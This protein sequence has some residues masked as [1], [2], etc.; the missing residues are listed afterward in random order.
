M[1][2]WYKKQ[3][4]ETRL[5]ERDAAWSCPEKHQHHVG[6]HILAER[7]GDLARKLLLV[8]HDLAR[9]DAEASRQCCGEAIS[10][11][12]F[13]Q[14]WKSRREKTPNS[15][16]LRDQG[17]NGVICNDRKRWKFH[18]WHV[19]FRLILAK[20]REGA[21]NGRYDWGRWALGVW[22]DTSLPPPNLIPT[23]HYSPYWMLSRIG[24]PTLPRKTAKSEMLILGLFKGPCHWSIN[25]K[26]WVAFKYISEHF[27]S[28]LFNISEI[29]RSKCW[30]KWLYS[31]K[32]STKRK[33]SSPAHNSLK[34]FK[35][36]VTIT[37]SQGQ[38]SL[39][40]TTGGGKATHRLCCACTE[41]PPSPFL[42]T[43]VQ[44]QPHHAF[45]TALEGLQRETAH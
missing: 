38:L 43:L 42:L 13:S 15:G 37:S 34:R 5:S 16:A 21:D 12:Y 33:K 36:S 45:E 39:H 29:S 18:F 35:T 4:C 2:S 6:G 20:W 40:L 32:T 25:F 8:Q 14:E 9:Q 44:G 17:D 28:S 41:T 19:N 1:L 26:H 10:P 3:A 27:H 23:W 11:F 24:A 7:S 30:V 31:S 22:A